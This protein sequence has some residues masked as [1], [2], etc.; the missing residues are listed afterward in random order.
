MYGAGFIPSLCNAGMRGAAG[1]SVLCAGCM[2][3]FGSVQALGCSTKLIWRRSSSRYSCRGQTL[4][5]QSRSFSRRRQL[6]CPQRVKQALPQLQPQKLVGRRRRLVQNQPPS[7]PMSVSQM[8]GPRR[9]TPAQGRSHPLQGVTRSLLAPAALWSRR[10]LPAA[11]AASRRIVALA[12]AQQERGL[13]RQLWGGCRCPAC[14]SLQWR[15][16]S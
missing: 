14:R 16:R 13:L 11:G 9:L 8:S 4:Q 15:S 2:P 10:A 1:A 7:W 3:C 12:A 5:L 6:A